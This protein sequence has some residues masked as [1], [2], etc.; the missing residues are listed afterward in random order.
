MEVKMDIKKRIEELTNIINDANYR[1]YVLDDPNLTDQEFVKYLHELEKL[2]EQYPEYVDP[3]SPTKRVG[4]EATDKFN[5]V[6]HKIPMLS[7][8]NVFNEEEIKEFD[9]RIKKE[10][11]I[12]DY[13]CEYKIDG[14]S[15]SLIYEKG[16][17]VQ[18]VTR[19][20]GVTGEDV[21]NNVKT[22]KSI[23]LKLPKPLDIEVRGE[24]FMHKKT[25][26]K[27]NEQREKQNLPILANVRNAAA[28]SLRQLDPKVAAQ[29]D[30]DAFIYY[31][32]EPEKYQIKTHY[33]ALEFMKSLGFKVNPESKLV[34]NI[35]GIFAY[36]AKTEKQREKLTYD[37]DGV[38]IKHNVFADQI[39]LGQTAKFP[40]WA[41][42]YKF[43]AQEAL[44]KLKD[45]IFT[46]GRTGRITP[47]AILEP[48]ILMGS[49]IARATLHNADFVR[50]KDLKI[51][52]VVSIKKAGDVI[53]AVTEAIISRRTGKEKP[54]VMISNCPMCNTPLVKKES[55]VDYF[56]PN[57][58][59]PARNINSLIHFVSRD[60]MNIEGLGDE[61]VEELYNLGFVK[62]IPDFY[63]LKNKKKELLEFDGY[64]ELSINKILDN[65]ENSKQNGLARVLFAIGI[66]GIGSKTAKSLAHKF[67]NID[68]LMEQSIEDLEKIPDIGNTLATNLHNYFA[69]HQDF[70]QT[71]K[72]I[73]INMNEV[74]SE[75]KEN[76]AITNRR[77]VITGTINDYTRN[78]IKDIL[79][80]YD[81]IIS[82]S[83]S[84]NTDVVIVGEN[85]GSK[86][87]KALALN[88]EIWNEEKLKNL[89][90]TLE[91]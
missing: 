39:E 27:L 90:A 38:V 24:V 86:Y 6:T 32:M 5:K 58:K 41:T 57:E 70:I 73:G 3:S 29:R 59:C 10:G 11:F 76:S 66:P 83:V 71:L 68:A 28:G 89:F 8:S 56:C 85:P 72:N 30:L 78:E 64:G 49:T 4:G 17:L 53:P 1:Y 77:F 23:P 12:P 62:T 22:I 35:N 33:E 91:L 47:N 79:E 55:Q 16:I 80:S 54:F 46:V 42:A 50:S 13:V 75:R 45:I 88:I 74:G 2:E 81:G 63:S 60:A 34:G 67:G 20:D 18:G 19:G 37:I 61:I 21:T 44:T 31:L 48:V 51:G 52:D 14:L 43:P 25:L 87:D 82:E 7:L 15:I 36:I 9:E 84:K 40:K 26:A 69:T 65:I